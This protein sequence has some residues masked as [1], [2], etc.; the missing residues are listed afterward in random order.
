MMGFVDEE[1]IVQAEPK[2]DGDC[3]GR[4]K[5]A[6]WIVYRP[7]VSAFAHCE[8]PQTVCSGSVLEKL[9]EP[10]VM[11]RTHWGRDLCH[12]HLARKL[13]SILAQCVLALGSLA[14]VTFCLDYKTVRVQLIQLPAAIWTTLNTPFLSSAAYTDS[15]QSLQQHSW[16][17]S[18]SSQMGPRY[19]K[20]CRR[21][22]AADAILHHT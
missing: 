10:S 11:D 20:Q 4:Q 17:C 19:Y 22:P 3:A 7:S 2:E 21:L 5:K 14:F 13:L 12:P 15:P 6:L 8:Q 9:P 18:L 1:Q 16:S